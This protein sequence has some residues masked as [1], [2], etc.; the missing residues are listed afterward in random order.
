MAVTKGEVIV[1][2]EFAISPEYK[3]LEQMYKTG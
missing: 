2:D 3:K 1:G